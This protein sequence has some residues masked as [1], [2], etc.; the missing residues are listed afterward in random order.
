M[1]E[2]E[3]FHKTL[4]REPVPGQVPT[5]ELVFFLTMEAFGKLHFHH[6]CFGQWDQM[7]AREKRLHIEDQA[8]LYI[9]TAK[10]YGHSAIFLHPN[11][12]DLDSIVRLMEIIREKSGDEY[13]LMID[14]DP[15]FSM[16]DGG[17]MME[18]TERL[19][20]DQ[21]G[22]HEEAKR[23]MEECQRFAQQMSRYPGLLDGFSMCADYCFNVNPFFSRE[24]FAEFIVPYLKQTIQAYHGKY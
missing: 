10:T 13:S 15:T 1:T 20:E 8:E 22:L 4:R 11:P 24:M 21:K 2:R 9:L 16:P 7:S 17:S 12:G 14:R 18:F 5:F 23:R 6:R 3:R 19:Y